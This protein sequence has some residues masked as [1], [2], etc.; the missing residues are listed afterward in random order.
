M[1]TATA[2]TP[3]QDAN[4]KAAAIAALAPDAAGQTTDNLAAELLGED[5]APGNDVQA[6]N[7]NAVIPRPRNTAVAKGAYY[8]MTDG[9]VEGQFDASDTRHP[10]LKIVQGSGPLS[11][12]FSHGALVLGEEQLVPPSPKPDQ[13]GPQIRF[14]PVA[15]KKSFQEVLGDEGYKAGLMPKVVDTVEEVEALGG[16]IVKIG[17]QKPTWRKSGRIIMLI[18]RPENSDHPLFAIE[19][20]GKVYAPAVFYAAGGSYNAV[21]SIWSNRSSMFVGDGASKKIKLWKHPWTFCVQKKPLGDYVTFQ[22]VVRLLIGEKFG[23]QLDEFARTLLGNPDQAE[24]G[25]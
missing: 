17:D 25:E 13:P 11:T 15:L 2:R 8:D 24:G 5:G 16:T 18:E 19:L 22:P 14:W 3:E 4:S 7:P 6:A 20:D 9:A 1:I 10:T 21:T 23:P 12:K